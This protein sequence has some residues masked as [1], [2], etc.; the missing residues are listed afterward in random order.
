[1][2]ITLT[3]I[4]LILLCSCSEAT[5]ESNAKPQDALSQ[6]PQEITQEVE[7]QPMILTNDNYPQDWKKMKAALIS[8]VQND[9]GVWC[10]IAGVNKEKLVKAL[11]KPYVMEKLKVTELS[12]LVPDQ[13]GTITYLKFYAENP[14]DASKNLSIFIKQGEHLI[15]E[16]FIEMN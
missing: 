10:A 8:K 7:E 5:V 14:N 1:M 2:K 11:N 15:L 13:K 12:D 16:Y 4:A 6:E 3:F 9:I